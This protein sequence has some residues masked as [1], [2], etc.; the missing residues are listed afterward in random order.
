MA[1]DQYYNPEN[2]SF[3]FTRLK[4]TDLPFNKR[5]HFPGPLDEEKELKIQTIK[6]KLVETVEECKRTK[7]KNSQENLKKSERDG[8]KTLEQRRNKGG[9]MGTSWFFRR[10]ISQGGSHLILLT[11]ISHH[12][13]NTSRTTPL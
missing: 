11:I 2:R 4:A 9:T 6:S 10:R 3:N 12:V 5:V 13:V 1:S 8:L 7:G